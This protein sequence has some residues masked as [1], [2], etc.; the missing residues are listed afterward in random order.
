MSPVANVLAPLGLLATLAACGGPLPPADVEISL[1]LGAG[2]ERA[3]VQGL[4]ARVDGVW[5]R[6]ASSTVLV[7]SSRGARPPQQLY[8]VQL[9]AGGHVTALRLHLGGNGGP[10]A[11]EAALDHALPPCAAGHISLALEH[12]PGL[13]RPGNHGAEVLRVL[14]AN[15]QPGACDDADGGAPPDLRMATTDLAAA[16]D[17]FDP[18][19]QNVVCPPGE[20]CQG[21]VCVVTDPCAMVVCPPGEVCVAGLCQAPSD[22]ASPPDLSSPPD[23]AKPGC[24]KGHAPR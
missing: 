4:E 8:R 20:A 1:A 7:A 2:I 17:A 3:S 15:S 24:D 18:A 13:M 5:R 23:L 11:P 19:C 16:V 21:G 9:R 12:A 22:L 14:V 6:L 10:R